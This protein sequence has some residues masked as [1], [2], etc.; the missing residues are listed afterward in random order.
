MLESFR[1]NLTEATEMNF[2]DLLSSRDSSSYINKEFRTDAEGI[3]QLQAK[4]EELQ[5]KQS[6]ILAQIKELNHKKGDILYKMASISTDLVK[7]DFKSEFYSKFKTSFTK[8]CK[9]EN[10]IEKEMEKLYLKHD[11]IND[12][13]SRYQKVL[14]KMAIRNAKKLGMD[15]HLSAFLMS[16]V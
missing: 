9:E 4:Q 14:T 2:K 7:L 3:K 8:L 1:E 12:E 5:T 13:I 16:Q 6:S 10:K 11:E 15:D